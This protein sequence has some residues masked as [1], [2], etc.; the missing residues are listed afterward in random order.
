M[1]LLNSALKGYLLQLSAFLPC[2]TSTPLLFS[3]CGLSSPRNKTRP[4]TVPEAERILAA[5]PVRH[6]A[7]REYRAQHPQ[8]LPGHAYLHDQLPPEECRRGTAQSEERVRQ[9]EG[10]MERQMQGGYE[11]KRVS[12]GKEKSV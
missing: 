11:L 5:V 3:L 1:L 7:Q 9:M 4:A 6:G 8:Q 10:R 12:A 2:L